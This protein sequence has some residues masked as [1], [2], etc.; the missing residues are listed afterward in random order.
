MT[1]PAG[2][3]HRTGT[4]GFFDP[5]L[6]FVAGGTLAWTVALGCLVARFL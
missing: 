1:Y 2:T 3:A 4:A 6:A 5:F